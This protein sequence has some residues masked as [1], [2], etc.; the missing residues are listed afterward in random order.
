MAQRNRKIQEIDNAAMLLLAAGR[1]TDEEIEL[2]ASAPHLMSSVWARIESE[3]AAVASVEKVPARFSLSAFQV[4]AAFAAVAAVVFLAASG[5]SVMLRSGDKQID[6]SSAAPTSE[7]ISLPAVE[8]RPAI[9][10]SGDIETSPARSEKRSRLQQT[11]N[12]PQ[13]RKTPTGKPSRPAAPADEPLEFYALPTMVDAVEA[14]R[15]ARVVRV[16]L[17]KATLVSLGANISLEGMNQLIKAD[18]LVGPD[19]VPRAIRLAE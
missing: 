13:P 15:D 8:V 6:V 3:K 5:V 18:L 14:T 19:G 7:T 17:P 16:E 9:G 12:R 4:R 11:F 1:L 2:A 10:Q